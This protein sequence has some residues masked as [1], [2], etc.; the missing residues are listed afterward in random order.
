MLSIPKIKKN[1]P[2]FFR[3]SRGESDSRCLKT[4]CHKRCTNRFWFASKNTTIMD[5]YGTCED[6]TDTMSMSSDIF[7][8]SPESSHGQDD[9]KRKKVPLTPVSVFQ[10]EMMIKSKCVQPIHQD[11]RTLSSS[12]ISLS[13]SLSS[14]SS[15]MGDLY[16]Y[17]FE[18][19]AEKIEPTRKISLPLREPGILLIPAV[20]LKIPFSSQSSQK[21]TIGQFNESSLSIF[22]IPVVYVPVSG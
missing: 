18:E 1:V 14:S 10:K 6:L 20:P 7:G 21:D 12:S 22:P 2:F 16:S 13:S 17:Q 19:R 5:S 4:L 9:E 8:L 3:G 11:S 15:H